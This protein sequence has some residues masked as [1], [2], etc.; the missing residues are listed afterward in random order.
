LRSTGFVGARAGDHLIKQLA[1]K[2][3]RV[4][5]IIVLASGKTQ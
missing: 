5:N 3:K 4:T 2:S 1:D